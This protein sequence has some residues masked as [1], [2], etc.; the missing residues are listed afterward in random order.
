MKRTG[1][2]AKI[3]RKVRCAVYTRKS[4]EEGLDMEFNSLD[5]QREAC[6][7]YIA[8][9]RSEG[10]VLVP[11]HYDDGG[12]SGGTLERPALKRLIADIENG[13]IDVV[14]VYKIDRLSRSLMDFAKLVE[15]FE[16][17]SVTFV[18]VTQSFNTTTSM[19]R[20]TL[21]I[22]LS[23]AQFEREVIGER[24][25]DKFAASR[26]KGMW[27]GGFVPLGYRVENR[28]LVIDEA[29]A[30]IVRMIFERFVKVGSATVLA[31][32]LIAERVTTR[33]GKPIDKGFLYK[34]LNNRVY[35]GDAVHKGVAYPG[36][37]EAIISVD[38]WN[39]VHTIMGESPRSRANKTRSAEPAMLKGLIFAPSGSAMSPTHTRKG[40]RLYRYY[41]TQSVLKCGP[42]TC[43]I[44]RV[45]AAEIEMAVVDQL[46]GLLR[47]PEM[48]VRTWMSA[49]R[50]DERINETEVRE[51]F[52]R[53]DPLWDELFPA[54]QARIV[55]LLVERVDVKT[56][57]VAIRLRTGGLTSLFAEMQSMI[58]PARKA[59]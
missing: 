39:R 42:E 43:P 53:L 9:Q 5:A 52:E 22:L 33:R 17:H 27:M 18:S 34:L 56:D 1:T 19:G 45:P 30:A 32:E 3:M 23:F 46:R 6:E 36:E 28:K 25:R 24:I 35:I 2:S 16:R 31:R 49:A 11:D 59:A 48:I 29:E 13:R 44:R 47:A 21:N 7:S 50:D 55:Q 54:E 4:S 12:I 26:K 20:L 10:W 37:H 51:A 8:S 57:G 38:L 15:V 40:D 41:V 14:V 58:P